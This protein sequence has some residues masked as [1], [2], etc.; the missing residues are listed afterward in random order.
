MENLQFCESELQE[1]DNSEHTGYPYVQINLQNKMGK[2]K[3]KD[4]DAKKDGRTEKAYIGRSELRGYYFGHGD[5]SSGAR[6]HKTV[7]G[8]DS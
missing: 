4:R 3:S 5:E 7:A 1:R 8:E 2:D 6:F